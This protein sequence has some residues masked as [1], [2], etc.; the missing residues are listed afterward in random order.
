MDNPIRILHLEDNSY[1]ATLVAI[2]LKKEYFSVDIKVAANHKDF[3]ELLNTYSFDVVLAD[4][5][6]PNYNGIDAL[7]YSKANFPE[8]PFIFVS[9]TLGEDKAILAMRYGAADFVDKNHI[10]KL[11][12]AL[13]R[14]LNEANAKK[15]LVS[16]NDAIVESEERLRYVVKASREMVWD[17]DV[18]TGTVNWNTGGENLF[19]YFP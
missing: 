17:M 10:E 18:T 12:Y 14:V 7:Q 3:E 19:G 4:N 11:G 9:G 2:E 8:M 5:N 16:L 15:Q 1:D 13:R 6:I